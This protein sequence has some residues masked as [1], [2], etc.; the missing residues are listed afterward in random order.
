MAAV[1]LGICNEYMY[2]MSM[3]HVVNNNCLDEAL[4][5]AR[6]CGCE[7]GVR[8]MVSEYEPEK[9]QDLPYNISWEVAAVSEYE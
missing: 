3:S 6:E 9:P 4:K 5:H 8:L 1:Y 2:N 7:I